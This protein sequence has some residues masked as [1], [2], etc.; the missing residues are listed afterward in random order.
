MASKLLTSLVAGSLVFS[1]SIAAAQV[2]APAL[3]PAAETGLGSNGE[4]RLGEGGDPEATTAIIFGLI[5][6][7]IAIWVA[8]SGGD[9]AETPGSP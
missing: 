3:D 7:I 2:G 5:V 4:S 9:G 6:F 8:T 1:S